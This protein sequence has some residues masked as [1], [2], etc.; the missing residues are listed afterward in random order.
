[1]GHVERYTPG[2]F[3]AALLLA[4]ILVFVIAMMG[5]ILV[6]GLGPSPY[7]DG[8][9][10]AN[11][12]FLMFANIAFWLCLGLAILIFGIVSGCT[13]V[14][15][16]LI[17]MLGTDDGRRFMHERSALKRWLLMSF[18]LFMFVVSPWSLAQ[19][20]AQNLWVGIPLFTLMFVSA[21]VLWGR[22]RQIEWMS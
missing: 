8:K 17:D 9:I 19:F 18:L 16:G 3:F 2:A 1:M 6:V 14:K 5:L 13:I 4:G 7:L 22:L 15:L 21:Y 11:N 20:P 12:I 10:T